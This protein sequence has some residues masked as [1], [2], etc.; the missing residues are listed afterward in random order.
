MEDIKQIYPFTLIL[1]TP[2]C[3]DESAGNFDPR[4]EIDDGSCIDAALYDCAM[5]SIL[6]LDL[7]DCNSKETVKALKLYTM[8]KAYLESLNKANRT[9]TDMYR[10]KLIDLC[11]CKTC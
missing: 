11:D 6:S 9:K 1:N 10:Q 8:Y 4:A 3:T 5:N 7:G 2:G